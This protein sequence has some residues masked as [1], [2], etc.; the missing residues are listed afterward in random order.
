MSTLLAD[1]IVRYQSATTPRSVLFTLV[2][3]L[4]SC[5]AA[6]P[7]RAQA[8]N[9]ML[10]RPTN[11]SVTAS[12]LFEQPMESY[13][14]YGA[15]RKGYKDSTNV[16]AH[17][18]GVPDNVV[19]GNCTSDTRYY[20][21]VRYRRPGTTAFSSTDEYMFQTQRAPGSSFRFLIEADEHLY[22]KKGIRSMYQVTLANQAKDSAD[23]LLSL[24]DIFGDDHTPATTT[25]ADMDALHKDYRQYLGTVCNS[26]PFFVCLGNHE[27]EMGYYLKQ[28]PPDNIAVYGTLWRK[29]Y[30]PNPVP[31]GFYTGNAAKEAFGID[32]PENYYAWT[33]G[34]ALFVVLDVYRH[35]DINEKPQNWDWT[36]GEAQYQWFR[37]TISKS[38]AKYK[39]VFAHHVRGQGR[40]AVDMAKGFEWGGYDNGGRWQFADKRPG[41]ELP[42]HQ[43]MVK[44]GVTVFFQGHDHLFAKEELDGIVYHEVPMPSDSSY[45]IGVLAN[46]DAYKG[47]TLNGTGHLRVDVKPGGVTVDF[48]RAYLPKDTVGGTRVNGEVAHSYTVQARTSDVPSVDEVRGARAYYSEQ[49]RSIN[50]VVDNI[51]D[52]TRAITVCT[53]NG[54]RVLSADME[55]GNTIARLNADGLAQGMY[56]VTCSTPTATMTMPLAIVH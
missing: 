30:Y 12:I 45:E 23:F 37:E 47:L 5:L 50:V 48:V 13:I 20:Y 44:Y 35:C 7:I 14:V 11:N 9:V 1:S 29:Y 15:S 34:D 31:D 55:A 43:L 51:A 54:E 33:W 10:A 16:I 42:I 40:G 56:L 18:A 32:L 8:P 2:L 49:N 21:R 27:G 38:T 22:D 53:M 52:V 6:V 46:A 25:S 41:W 28:T 39:F 19:I 36:L 17:K 3:V 26:M 24:G 4:A